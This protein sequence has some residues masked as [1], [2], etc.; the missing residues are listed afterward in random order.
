MKC[1]YIYGY[2]FYTFQTPAS[3]I[4]LVIEQAKNLDYKPVNAEMP[5]YL[6]YN[7]DNEKNITCYYNKMLYDFLDSCLEP[8]YKKHFK[9]STKHVINDLWITKTQFGA[10]FSLHKHTY[11]VFSG[12]LYLENSNTGTI[13]SFP[14]NFSQLWEHFTLCNVQQQTYESKSEKGKLLIWPSHILHKTSPHKE[15]K[16][17]YSVA[18]NSFWDGKL[19]DKPS[20][21][22]ELSTVPAQE[23]VSKSS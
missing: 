13:F 10:S 16:V 22:L 6:G 21:F 1:D 11:S 19:Y 12:V 15:K 14:D 18:F 17:R 7:I 5:G 3:I 4:D 23:F 2:P 8:I 20:G 9:Y